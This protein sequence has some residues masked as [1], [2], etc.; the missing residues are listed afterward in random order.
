MVKCTLKRK[1]SKQSLL[2]VRINDPGHH[3]PGAN[4][5]T[6]RLQINFQKPLDKSFSLWYNIYITKREET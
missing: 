3:C 6:I 4:S 2:F 5:F 1:K